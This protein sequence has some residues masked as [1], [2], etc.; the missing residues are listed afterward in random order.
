MSQFDPHTFD[1]DP[2][3]PASLRVAI[4]ELHPA[5]PTPPELDDRILGTARL[6]YHARQRRSGW[7]RGIAAGLAAAAAIAIAVR[8]FSPAAHSPPA[9]GQ[10][11]QLAQV[12]DINHDGRV[13]ILDAYTLARHLARHDALDHAWDINGDGVVDQKDVDLIAHLAVQTIPEASQ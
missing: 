11:P 1:K 3:L 2:Q 4:R 7:V 13:D 6:T 9:A 12:A 5:V 10:R 8:V